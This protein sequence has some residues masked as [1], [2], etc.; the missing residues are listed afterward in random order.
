MTPL[1]LSIFMCCPISVPKPTCQQKEKEFVIRLTFG[2]LDLGD[3]GIKLF[4]KSDLH[5]PKS[6][7]K[8][9]KQLDCLIKLLKLLNGT[10][11]I[12]QQGYQTA[13]TFLHK[14][15]QEQAQLA[16]Q[17][18]SIGVQLAFAFDAAL[19]QFLQR[20]TQVIT[21]T[22][23]EESAIE[24]GR[25][26]L[27]TFMRD[28]LATLF[29][30]VPYGHLPDLAL[31][32]SLT[33]NSPLPAHNMLGDPKLDTPMPPPPAS[34]SS[35]KWFTKNPSPVADWQLPKNTNFTEVFDFNDEKRQHFS[36][37]WPKIPQHK[38]KE[39]CYSSPAEKKPHKAHKEMKAKIMAALDY[40]KNT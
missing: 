23:N 3:E 4:A 7:D 16:T 17:R 36:S 32:G 31:P 28:N 33:T 30:Q 13:Q 34:G 10:N 6:F 9:V 2:K 29:L 15:K 20:F 18:A 8:L 38:T 39:V 19:Q 26:T 5:I 25:H 37:H 11:N 40:F 14:N 22:G 27:Q 12:G 24:K 21:D 35:P 1:G